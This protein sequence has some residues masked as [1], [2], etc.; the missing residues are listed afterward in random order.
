M[1][2]S[3]RGSLRTKVLI[4]DDW[5]GIAGRSRAVASLR[6]YA[7]VHVLGYASE[8]EFLE[9]ARDSEV[10][11]PIRERRPITEELLAQLPQLRHI[12][13]TGGGVAHIDMRAAEAAGVLVTRTGGASSHSVAELAV[14]LMI[15]SRRRMSE[16]MQSLKNG[17]WERSLGHQLA[18]SVMGV[19][20]FG[21][22]GQKVANITR[23]IGMDV[24]VC[25]RRADDGTI[26]GFEAVSL[27]ELCSRADVVSLHV[28]LSD[29]TRG[30]ISRNELRAIG[31][32]GLLVNTARADL[33][34]ERDLLDALND[35]ELGAAALDVFHAEPVKAGDPLVAHPSVTSTP[36]LGWRTEE[37]MDAYLSGAVNNILNWMQE[38][39]NES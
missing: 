37:S 17:E 6:E 13:Q 16:A 34:V 2:P 38:R 5:D 1:H 10:L 36:H 28:E 7:D 21:A 26:G 24:I 29:Q 19:V 31:T 25:S 11:V 32:G 23:A 12:A 22:T 3:S 8:A 30:M 39:T 20:G 35:G 4:M 27:Q 33:V 9:V 18:G 15:A 14:A